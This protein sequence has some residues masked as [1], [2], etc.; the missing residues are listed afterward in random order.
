MYFLYDKLDRYNRLENVYHT[1]YRRIKVKME[2]TTNFREL[3][4][5]LC[6]L[7][8]TQRPPMVVFPF[9]WFP[10]RVKLLLL[11]VYGKTYR[12]ITHVVLELI[13][14]IF[15]NWVFSSSSTTIIIPVIL[16]TWIRLYLRNYSQFLGWIY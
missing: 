11:K 16:P 12:K 10:Q 7:L 13:H 14:K 1:F 6:L 8:T 9:S 5:V 4:W 3:L 2:V 15:S